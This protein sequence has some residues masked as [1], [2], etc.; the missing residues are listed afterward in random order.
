MRWHLRVGQRL[1]FF[2]APNAEKTSR[3][4]TGKRKERQDSC[5]SFIKSV[6]TRSQKV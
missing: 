2:E 1:I 6:Y 3:G 5:G 4:D